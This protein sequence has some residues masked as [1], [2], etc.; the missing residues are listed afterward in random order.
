MIIKSF[1]FEKININKFNNYLFYGE[2]AGLKNELIAENFKKKFKNNI[3]NYEEITIL[4][5]E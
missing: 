2:N 4:Q 5:N 3:Y 1:E